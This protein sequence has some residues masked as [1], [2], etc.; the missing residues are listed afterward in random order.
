ME[1]QP[2]VPFITIFIIMC[3]FNLWVVVP[4]KV[5]GNSGSVSQFY[6]TLSCDLSFTGFVSDCKS[7]LSGFVRFFSKV[8]CEL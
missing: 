2:V 4:L 3:S 7:E 6:C 5:M 1:N 8:E